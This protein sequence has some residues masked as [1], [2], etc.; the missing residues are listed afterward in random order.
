MGAT[1]PSGGFDI[2]NFFSKNPA[3][4]QSA[5]FQG[6]QP[7][8]FHNPPQTFPPNQF[9]SNAA[10]FPPTAGNPYP[11]SPSA[12]P[13]PPPTQQAPNMYQ[14]YHQFQQEQHASRPP[15][16]PNA[17]FSPSQPAPYS[18]PQAPSQ[19][20]PRASQP[21]QTNLEP[22]PSTL[23]SLS[24][25]QSTG[26]NASQIAGSTPLDGARLMAL[27]T[28]HSATEGIADDD[29][30]SLSSTESSP[31]DVSNPAPA[32]SPAAP[33]APPLNAIPPPSRIATSKVAKGRFVAGERIVY[34][35]D[36]HLPG[37]AQPQLEVNPIT[38]YGS[39]PVLVAGK[40]IAVNKNYVCYALRLA[41]I[42]ILNINTALRALLRGH[43][44]V[45]KLGNAFLTC[46]TL[47]C[48]LSLLY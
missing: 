20:S 30:L 37:E 10:P 1:G 40:R 22:K 34:D 3:Y 29:I 41:T 33:T 47:M 44:E 45:S 4:P 16:Y 28:T 21:Q 46:S 38:V 26:P 8:Q 32:I 43:A 17:P 15:P 2:Q 12:P 5:Q 13:P 11:F 42:R 39:D 14:G 6:I 9:P 25:P 35:V 18:Q 31:V 19:S 24:L 27:L 36:V 48:Y 7:N 23:P